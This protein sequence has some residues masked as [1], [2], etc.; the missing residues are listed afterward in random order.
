MSD[1]NSRSLTE[2]SDSRFL[3]TTK[4]ERAA[5]AV[6]DRWT[7]RYPYASEREKLYEKIHTQQEELRTYKAKVAEV[8]HALK[9]A[10]AENVRL[11][12]A[13]DGHARQALQS[14]E[15]ARSS[16][17]AARQ[18]GE[19]A[20]Q[21]ADA[22]NFLSDQCRVL[23]K[24]R[25]D[26]RNQMQALLARLEGERQ[27][28]EQQVTVRGRA[29][30]EARNEH[31]IALR[32][33]SDERKQAEAER[34]RTEGRLATAIDEARRL[35]E[36]VY[37]LG[38]RLEQAQTD[39]KAQQTS[40]D[41]EARRCESTLTQELRRMEVRAV[42]AEER[43][44]AAEFKC[45][46]AHKESVAA[47]AARD[48]AQMAQRT[49]EES[50]RS[51][52][53]REELAAMRISANEAKAAAELKEA[54][55]ATE[56]SEARHRATTED[57][58]N[59]EQ[60]IG[61]L[62]GELSRASLANAEFQ[63]QVESLVEEMRAAD[64]RL[65]EVERTH[66][67]DVAELSA[68]IAYEQNVVDEAE[69]SRRKIAERYEAERSARQDEKLEESKAIRM[70]EQALD[71]ER[72]AHERERAAHAGCEAHRQELIALLNA[73]SPM[74][75]QPPPP[76]TQNDATA[77]PQTHAL[78]PAYHQA[79]GGWVGVPAP[80]PGSPGYSPMAPAPVAVPRVMYQSAGYAWQ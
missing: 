31:A 6:M 24:L 14:E 3:T 8:Q 29:L 41:L 27:R 35:Q 61:R 49:A 78:L 70:L 13:V 67:N 72:F 26:E 65:K 19:A 10:V 64:V 7:R 5:P 74:D 47:L 23:E 68:R 17:E 20:K 51:A 12:E 48:A 66:R 33:W 56:R 50:L 54:K 21:S 46:V 55:A 18:S 34:M 11:N 40:A 38:K 60:E 2:G 57:L 28:L 75:Q 22:A 80:A 39:A 73:S 59:K 44:S 53:T 16:G 58:V 15:T 4:A 9:S 76:L 79:R 62:Q 30:E 32:S 63:A 69:S 71:R 77:T 36:Q 42:Q 25:E 1:A 45:Q 52:N 43:I 37:G